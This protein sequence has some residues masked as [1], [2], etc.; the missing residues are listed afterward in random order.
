VD[1][2]LLIVAG[3]LLLAAIVFGL[4]VRQA[5]K[6][7]RFMGCLTLVLLFL[8]AIL[9]ALLVLLVSV[10]TKGYKALVR[11]ELAATAYITPL[12]NQQFRAKIVRPGAP[13]TAFTI[14]GDELYMDARILKWKPIITVL[15]LHTAYCLDRVSG[16]YI[17]ISD[18]H[19]KVRTLYSLNGGMMP[20][21]LFFLRVH[22]GFLSP[23]LDAQYGSAAFVPV[24]DVK[25]V[26]ILVT[27]GGLIARR[28]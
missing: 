5:W 14:A 22:Y 8:V 2:V 23:I 12:G 28:E 9:S 27:A 20:W 19:T 1:F 25:V 24:N 17:D 21:D 10:G 13:D 3:V 6:N 18:E 11:E 7:R 15:G 4:L 26:K 16:R